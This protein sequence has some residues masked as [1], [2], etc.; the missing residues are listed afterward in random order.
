MGSAHHGRNG[1]H[2]RPWVGHDV[3]D[4]T[5][6]VKVGRN[7]NERLGE[8]MT[9]NR[10]N[11]EAWLEQSLRGELDALTPEQVAA[12]EAALNE[13]PE[14]ASRVA[15]VVPPLDGSAERVAMPTPA[16][17]DRVWSRVESGLAA[18]AVPQLRVRPADAA[19]AGRRQPHTERE[20]TVARR[21]PLFR[22]WP[23]VSAVAACIALVLV[24]RGFLPPA[25]V[26][27]EL[28]SMTAAADTEILELEV[29][30]DAVA[31]VDFGDGD[32]G[33]VVISV[34]EPPRASG[35]A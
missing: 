22:L 29:Y 30:G 23:S 4:T 35:G 24:W 9:P 32:N 19:T 15:G 31:A 8:K 5:A 25:P 17:W 26:S 6:D 10:D 14:L 1:D 34:Y 7:E 27:P 13:S 33:A 20:R 18:G 11:L 12:L 16:E 3:R 2:G 21:P 28:W